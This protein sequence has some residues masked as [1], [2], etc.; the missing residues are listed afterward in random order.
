MGDR[1][2]S[3]LI[4]AFQSEKKAFCLEGSRGLIF[5]C[6]LVRAL[7]YKDPN[8]SG[9]LTPDAALG[10][11]VSFLE[12]NSGAIE[13]LI[14]WIGRMENKDWTEALELQLPVEEDEEEEECS[15]L[16]FPECSAK[17]STIRHLGAGECESICPSKFQ[18]KDPV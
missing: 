7:G 1:S 2:L 17:C 6:T 3:E 11:L 9:Q 15:K 13:A 8:Y 10:D 12:D 5:L 16:P 14:E 4:E 18:K